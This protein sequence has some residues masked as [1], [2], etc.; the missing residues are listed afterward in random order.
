MSGKALETGKSLADLVLAKLPESL[1]AEASKIFT[2]PEAADAL[3]EL[4]AR[5]LAQSEL[6]RQL[7]SLREKEAQVLEDYNKNVAWFEENKPKLDRLPI[8]EA[9]NARLKGT[10]PPAAPPEPPPATGLTKEDLDKILLERDRGYANVLGLGIEVGAKHLHLF[11]E[12]PDMRGV[13]EL[14]GKKGLSLEAAYQEKYGERLAAKAKEAEDAR[15]N[16]IVEERVS[17]ERKKFAESPYP[18]RNASPSVLDILE[19][20]NDKPANHT[21]DSAVAEYERLVAARGA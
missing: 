17:T 15:I 10:P 8:L 5:G 18:L 6:S 20:P 2:A 13:I 3:V 9:E 1:R 21:V 11:G 19:N 16:K 7:D 14:A 12:P 4:G